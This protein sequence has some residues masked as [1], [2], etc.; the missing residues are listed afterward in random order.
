[1]L[2]RLRRPFGFALAA[3]LALFLRPEAG[4]AQVIVK[5]NDTVGFR[6]GFQLQTW[7][8]W[9][10]DPI[11]QGYQQSMF[12]RRVRAILAGTL[13]KD[14]SFFF[15]TDNPRMGNTIGTATKALNAGFLV[16]DAFGEWRVLGN[17][18]LLLDFGKMIAP[19]TRNTLQS[20][21]SHLSW[22]GG[23]FDFLQGAGTGSDASRDVGFQLKTYLVDDHLELR[24]G[25][26]D[27]FRAA[28]NAGGAGS[29]NS[30]RYAGYGHYNFFDTEKGYVYVGTNLG[31]KRIVS[32]GGGF[33]TQST[34]SSYGA[35]MMVDWPI[36][37]PPDPK[38]RDAITVHFDYIHFD[39][40]C[41]LN[42][43]GTARLTNCLIPTLA[44][45]DE[46]FTDLGYFFKDLNLQPFV[47]FEWNGF[48]DDIDHARDQRRYGGGFNYYVSPANQNLK[49]TAGYERIVPNTVGAT[50]WKQKNTNHFLVQFQAYYF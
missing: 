50:T 20:T 49:I 28:A 4:R 22:D 48:V 12:I 23:T 3:G 21:S 1:M 17:D 14:V 31:K 18:M 44:K 39:G 2:P 37:G 13:A 16:Q 29:R 40:G 33:D 27:G 11:S 19:E 25:V 8:D 42:A 35:D 36:G 10:Q 7:A 15:Q 43:A 45:Q 24:A 6:F 38:G 46:I 32:I 41:D 34:Y 5:V 26:F 30:Y 47:R 9:T